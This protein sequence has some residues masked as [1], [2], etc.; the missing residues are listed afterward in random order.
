MMEIKS[1]N[2]GSV[3]FRTEG[4][5]LVGANLYG[6]NLYGA[7]LSGADLRSANLS[8]ANLSSA[9]LSGADLYGANL[10]GA[11]LSGADLSSANLY[12]ANLS[13]A[14]LPDGK[15]LPEYIAWLPEGL[16]TQGGKPLADVVA[17]WDRH[18]WKDCPMHCA[19][20]VRC[21]EQVPEC[22]RAAAATFVALYDGGHIP[23]PVIP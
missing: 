3:L 15:T 2:D 23:K 9:N 10:S 20:D 8:S 5:N 18:T 21:L 14:M 11:N 19:F 16:L 22:W 13:G 6:A 7:N 17:S 12:G 1:Y 4:A